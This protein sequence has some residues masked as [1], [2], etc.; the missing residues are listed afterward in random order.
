LPKGYIWRA[1]LSNKHISK[2]LDSWFPTAQEC[3]NLHDLGHRMGIKQ[4]FRGSF[5]TNY[6]II[7]YLH[8]F[9]AVSGMLSLTLRLLWLLDPLSFQFQCPESLAAAKWYLNELWGPY[10][11][12]C[13]AKAFWC[14]DV[15]QVAVF[16]PGIQEKIY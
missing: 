6:D 9:Q 8:T 5:S 1:A 15:V 7:Q 13:D 10:V 14:C 2:A 4:T 11:P 12:I 16:I 3:R